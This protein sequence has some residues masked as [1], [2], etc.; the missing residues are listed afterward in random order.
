[1]LKGLILALAISPVSA[2][3]SAIQ[4]DTTLNWQQWIPT[5]LGGNCVQVS[6]VSFTNQPG[7]ASRFTS[8]SG[9]GLTQGIVL[10]SGAL[11]GDVSY[12]PSFF[13]GS[14]FP[15]G[16]SDSLLEQYALQ[17]LGYTGN[18][19]SFD[20]TRL[21][22]DFTPPANQTV[23]I[24]FVFA[25]EEYPEFAPPNTNFYNDIF[26]F[27]VR[28][29]DSTNYTNIALVPGT[30]LPVTIGNIN[31]VTNPSF[32]IESDTS[33]EFAFDGYTTPITATF[34]CIGG[35]TYHMIIAISDIG[36]SFFDS[37]VFL[38]Q[39]SNSSQDVNGTAAAGFGQMEQGYAELFGYSMAPGAFPRL[40]SVACGA[41][42]NFSFTSVE[43]G[44]YLIHIV[45][46]T[47][48]Y[49]LSVPTYY[50]GAFLWEEAQTVA[51]AC[52]AYATSAAN[53]VINTGPGGISGTI[54]GSSE[55]F[56]LRSE[57]LIP[58]PNVN[59][60][61]QDSASSELRGFA[62]TDANGI[63]HFNNLAYGT[64][65]VLPDVAGVPLI[66]YRKVVLNATN[67]Q[68]ENIS[69][70]LSMDGVLNVSDVVFEPII[71]TGLNVEWTVTGSFRYYLGA[72]EKIRLGVDTLINDTLY[73][74]LYIDGI[75]NASDVFNESEKVLLGG[76]RQ[77]GANLYLRYLLEQ[78]WNSSIYNKDLLYFRSDLQIGDTLHNRFSD[79]DISFIEITNIDTITVNG[80]DRTRWTYTE[81]FYGQTEY[82][83]HGI[84]N[85][86]GWFNLGYHIC[87]DCPFFLTICWSDVNGVSAF[88]Q[89]VFG[90][91]DSWFN[92][93][94]CFMISGGINEIPTLTLKLSPNPGNGLVS[95]Q[96][97]KQEEGFLT[98]RDVSGRLQMTQSVK[99][100]QSIDLGNLSAGVYIVEFR[101]KQGQSGFTRWIKE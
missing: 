66:D 6:N 40:D 29:I 89:D 98:I 71:E 83:V 69:F 79:D 56:R 61:L 93:N 59:V 51:I 50:G 43:D 55:G 30:T 21:E 78:P 68:E 73:Q 90:E 38:E 19:T 26:G 74:T 25:S 9:I 11:G 101:N 5:I 63:Y 82:F 57:E 20:A 76:I 39:Q 45:P 67:E 31:A 14:S 60:F 7:S 64:Y 75:E 15:F 70:Q 10:S 48:A 1:F 52:D 4:V 84:G 8:G 53:L 36:D 46:D 17:D 100:N 95:I 72:N 92:F 58:V 54:G 87:S 97:T 91:D 86:T 23:T 2:Q 24:R 62:R 33:A 96:M 12:D 77:E 42:G 27:F 99:G 85:S 16:T 49:P 94:E 81:N 37:A 41:G 22:F 34:N 47:S 88:Y 18:S 28:Q 44:L 35:V 32:Y 80:I 65:Y 13:L 3:T